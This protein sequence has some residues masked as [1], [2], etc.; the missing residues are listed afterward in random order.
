MSSVIHKYRLRIEGG[1][2]NISVPSPSPK[3]V[4]V[5][6]QEG[7]LT[8]WVRHGVPGTAKQTLR[9]AVVGTGHP[10]A[11]WGWTSVGTVQMRD[12]YVW[13]VLQWMDAIR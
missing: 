8:V 5:G 12:G 6:E 7:G 4:H 9:L 1:E 13:H 11:D 2:Q 3:V 10:I